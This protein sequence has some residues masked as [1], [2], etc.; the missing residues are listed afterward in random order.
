MQSEVSGSDGNTAS[1]CAKEG[2]PLPLATESQEAWGTCLPPGRQDPYACPR[3]GYEMVVFQITYS[4]DGERKTV[5][6]FD[7]LMNQGVLRDL[8]VC[9]HQL[10][11]RVKARCLQLS[12]G[13]VPPSPLGEQLSLVPDRNSP[14][15]DFW[16]LEGGRSVRKQRRLFFLFLFLS[17]SLSCSLT[18][19]AG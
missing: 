7:W 18:S 3:C 8:S 11:G 16:H 15:K 14:S 6:G 13:D 4:Q 12:L 1:R 2:S 9:A 10:V 19:S 5:G 17:L